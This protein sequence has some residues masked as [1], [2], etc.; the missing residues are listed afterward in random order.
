LSSIDARLRRFAAR[1]A[2]A[3]RITVSTSSWGENET[4]FLDLKGDAGR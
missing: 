1:V 2:A 3:R 4:V